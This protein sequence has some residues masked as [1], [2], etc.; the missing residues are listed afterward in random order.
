MPTPKTF[1]APFRK[2]K[3]R[4]SKAKRTT[5][6]ENIYRLEER[7]AKLASI[8]LRISVG[9]LLATL[10]IVIVKETNDESLTIEPFSVADGLEKGGMSG[11]SLSNR[12]HSLLG[13]ISET[14][15]DDDRDV[16]N[17]GK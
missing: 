5:I 1:H 17:V 8:C 2:P 4:A 11:N 13:T 14:S 7:S 15:L 10:V 3:S 12:F 6:W 9:L 16:Q